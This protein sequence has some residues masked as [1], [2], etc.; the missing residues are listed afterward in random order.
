MERIVTQP[1]LWQDVTVLTVVDDSVVV[2]VASLLLSIELETIPEDVIVVA[3]SF[4]GTVVKSEL[5]CVSEIVEEE[6]GVSA[7]G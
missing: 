5:V 4:P 7:T 1:L 6:I 2:L 3:V